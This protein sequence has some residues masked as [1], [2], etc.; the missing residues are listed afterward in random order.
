M[1]WQENTGGD[2]GVKTQKTEL[3]GEVKLRLGNSCGKQEQGP[4]LLQFFVIKAH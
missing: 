2:E 1:E 3:K 4:A